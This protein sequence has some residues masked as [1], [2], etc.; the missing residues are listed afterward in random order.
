MNSGIFHGV[1]EICTLF[2]VITQ[3]SVAFLY[4]HF[5]TAYRTQ[6]ATFNY[7]F[8]LR[9]IPEECRSN[10]C[11]VVILLSAIFYTFMQHHPQQ[12]SQTDTEQSSGHK[13]LPRLTIHTWYKMFK[14][15]QQTCRHPA[16]HVSVMDQEG[17]SL[18][19]IRKG[20]QVKEK[21]QINC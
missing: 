7:H 2:W 8:T 19:V 11:C 9:N 5:R 21:Y 17:G 3:L 15:I 4:L 18:I 12:F 20:L 1:D 14:D 13:L 10:Q 6:N 16:R